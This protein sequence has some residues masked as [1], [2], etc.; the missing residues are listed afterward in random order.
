MLSPLKFTPIISLN[1]EMVNRGRAF[2]FFYEAVVPAEGEH[3]ISIQNGANS[4]YLFSRKVN[5]DQPALRYEVRTGAVISSYGPP[6]NPLPMNAL[7]QYPTT[8]LARA[9]TAS[10][11]GVLVDIDIAGGSDGV[12][13]R[14]EGDT[15]DDT[16]DLKVLPPDEEFLIRLVNPNLEA[17]NVLVYMKW[18]EMPY[19]A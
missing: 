19:S 5:S 2:R 7:L 16:D 3:T 17:A 10:S 4:I 13:H 6:I 9:C 8:N 18:F 14:H 15:M 12:G 11:I 1:Q